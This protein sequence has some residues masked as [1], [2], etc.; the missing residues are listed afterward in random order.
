MGA[1]LELLNKTEEELGW[2]SRNHNDLVT[3]FDQQFVAI[4][5]TN[6]IEHD[7]DLQVVIKNLKSHNL[8]PPETL[9]RF[10][11]KIKTIFF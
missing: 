3:K 9:I 7:K 11:S 6:V 4:N 10:V 5:G 8:N 2:F 1:E